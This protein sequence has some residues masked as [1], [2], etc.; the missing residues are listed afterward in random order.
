LGRYSVPP[1]PVMMRTA[2]VKDATYHDHRPIVGQPAS[3]PPPTPTPPPT[4]PPPPP[5]TPPP[6]SASAQYPYRSGPRKVSCGVMWSAACI[7]MMHAYQCAPMSS[8]SAHVSIVCD[9]VDSVI[10][11]C[12]RVYSREARTRR[13]S[14]VSRIIRRVRTI[15]A[16]S[17][18][19]P[20]ASPPTVGVAAIDRSKLSGTKIVDASKKK[21]PLR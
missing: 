3:A 11:A 9:E 21:K 5:P 8:N 12:H 13:A 18:K 10:F 1:V 7:P 2:Q 16:E 4:P 14:L 15:V 17:A 6:S 19:P 20:T